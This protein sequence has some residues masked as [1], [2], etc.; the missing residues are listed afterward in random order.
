MRPGALTSPDPFPRDGDGFL[1]PPSLDELG[2]RPEIMEVAEEIVALAGSE[3]LSSWLVER[4]VRA[5]LY[6]DRVLA[7]RSS[8]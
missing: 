6:A 1:R 3:A 5:V 8:A 7:C 4:L 2:V